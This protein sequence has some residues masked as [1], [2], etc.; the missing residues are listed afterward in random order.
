VAGA[1]A[2]ARPQRRPAPH[3]RPESGLQFHRDG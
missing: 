3:P 1:H 2:F